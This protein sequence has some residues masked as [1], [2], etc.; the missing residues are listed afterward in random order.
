[1]EMRQAIEAAMPMHLIEDEEGKPRRV[2]AGQ[3]RLE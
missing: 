1:M 3:G 2:R